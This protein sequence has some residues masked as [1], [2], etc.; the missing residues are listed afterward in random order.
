MSDKRK[1]LREH[2]RA[3]WCPT[4]KAS[5]VSGHIIL[6]VTT[7]QKT[8]N[9][10]TLGDSAIRPCC[11]CCTTGQLGGAGGDYAWIRRRR[12]RGGEPSTPRA[13]LLP[14]EQQTNMAQ[15]VHYQATVT[16]LTR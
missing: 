12:A 16:I 10:K 9:R 2:Y 15:C 6:S 14:A 11:C 4:R 13:R 5:D 3:T 1:G 8:Q 7:V